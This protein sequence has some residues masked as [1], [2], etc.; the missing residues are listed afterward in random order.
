[1]MMHGHFLPGLDRAFNLGSSTNRWAELQAASGTFLTRATIK[2][3]PIVTNQDARTTV[4]AIVSAQSGAIINSNR[5]TD[6]YNYTIPANT[7]SPSGKLTLELIGSVTNMTAG[8]V[9]FTPRMY[10]NG[11][12]I[13]G[14]LFAVPA[15]PRPRDYAMYVDICSLGSMTGQRVRGTV[16]L[17]LSVAGSITGNGDFG[18]TFSAGANW[19]SVATSGTV[20]FSTPVNLQ[21]SMT[22]GS[23]TTLASYSGFHCILTHQPFPTLL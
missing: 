1:M 19:S 13:W 21:V 16:E 23:T 17:G 3:A 12:V 18:S 22:M 2:N 20:D 10:L 14:D 7:L 9:N 6:I 11:T 8:T 15:G 4:H 5:E